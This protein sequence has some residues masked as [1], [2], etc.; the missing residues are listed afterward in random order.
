MRIREIPD[1][2]CW[3]KMGTEAGEGLDDILRRKEIERLANGGDFTWG[4]GNPLGESILQLVKDVR[5]PMVIF[6][7][8]KSKPK[9]IDEKP[10]S[11][12]LWLTYIDANGIERPLPKYSLL[13][14]RGH[15]DTSKSKR[16]H[17]ALLCAH[18]TPLKQMKDTLLNS[19]ELR[20]LITGK[21]VGYSQVTSVVKRVNES[22][23][24]EK[25]YS[26]GFKAYLQNEGQVKLASAVRISSDS[27]K[28]V[29]E[30]ANNGSVYLWKRELNKLKECYK[31]ESSTS[32][33]LSPQLSMAF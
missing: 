30:A 25:N 1:M 24:E 32:I 9:L 11:L 12:L 13:T 15:T 27:L 21:P 19:T 14:S 22:K 4:V 33:E 16:A 5:D 20:N 29:L 17:Y 2:F 8:M 18:K 10:D 31:P 3:S 6:T 28:P 7:K 26:I 23:D